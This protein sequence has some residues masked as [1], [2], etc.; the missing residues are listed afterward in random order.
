LDVNANIKSKPK[1]YLFKDSVGCADPAECMEICGNS[2][3]CSNY[4]YPTLVIKF[5]PAGAK[6]MSRYI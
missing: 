6:G 1:I 5:M 4:A 2:R 3:G